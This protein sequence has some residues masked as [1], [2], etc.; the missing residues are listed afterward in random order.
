[1]QSSGLPWNLPK[2]A[3]SLDLSN[4]TDAFGVSISVSITFL[5]SYVERKF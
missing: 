3:L 1:M 2:K 4:L 5:L